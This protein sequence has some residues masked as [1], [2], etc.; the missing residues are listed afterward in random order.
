MFRAFGTSGMLQHLT[1]AENLSFLLYDPFHDLSCTELTWTY[2][3]TGFTPIFGFGVCVL[4][5]LSQLVTFMT[6]DSLC[7]R[8]LTQIVKINYYRLMHVCT[9]KRRYLHTH[10]P[11]LVRNLA[12]GDAWGQI[13]TKLPPEHVDTWP[14]LRFLRL[15]KDAVALSRPVM[16]KG[17]AKRM[18]DCMLATSS[19]AYG[20]AAT[21]SIWAELGS[22]PKSRGIAF[23]RIG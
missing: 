12:W 15:W 4:G 16:G 21:G 8:K 2:R 5:C 20:M 11:N 22:W 1:A 23:G 13:L 10:R 9:P 3:L 19:G 6:W 17:L 7:Q 14:E 18:A